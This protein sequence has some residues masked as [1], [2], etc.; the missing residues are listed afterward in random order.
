[1]KTSFINNR[2]EICKQC[3]IYSNG[4][5]NNNL[6]L[7]PITGDVATSKKKGYI[8]GCGCKISLKVKIES[9]KCKLGK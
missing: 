8:N 4:I 3:P 2:L 9:E 6:Y 1:M 5:C 7:N